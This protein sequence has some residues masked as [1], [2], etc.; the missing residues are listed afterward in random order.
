MVSKVV[1]VVASELGSRISCEERVLVHFVSAFDFLIVSYNGGT[2]GRTAGNPAELKT[3]VFF[4][5][6]VQ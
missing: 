1:D 2:A 6:I 4:T 3:L 5:R